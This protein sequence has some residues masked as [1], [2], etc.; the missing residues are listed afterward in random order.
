M[1]KQPVTLRYVGS[2]KAVGRKKPRKYHNEKI[3][4][5]GITF[6][7]LR[8]FG[9]WKELKLLER[10]GEISDLRVHPKFPLMCGTV[11]IKIRSGRYH[12]GRKISYYADFSYIDKKTHERIVEDVKGVDTAIS[13]LKR[14]IVEAQYGV[15][16]VIV[17]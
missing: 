8:E 5:A 6:D 4:F 10:A 11:D 13:R 2:G 17:R 1:G 12:G 15:Q 16:V 3:T 14:G 7:S 9:R